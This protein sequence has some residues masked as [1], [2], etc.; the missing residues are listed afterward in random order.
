MALN[1]SYE[2]P[3]DDEFLWQEYCAI[4][5]N[6][7]NWTIWDKLNRIVEIDQIDGEVVKWYNVNTWSYTTVNPVIWTDVDV[8]PAPASTQ[9]EVMVDLLP[10][11]EQNKFIRRFVI[12]EDGS[13]Q[14]T[15]DL[16]LDW[17]TAYT[18][19]WTVL[20]QFQRKNAWFQTIS[21]TDG[22]VINLTVP[23]G[24]NFAELIFKSSWSGASDANS[25]ISYTEEAGSPNPTNTGST[26]YIVRKEQQFTLQWDDELNNFK[27]IALT[28]YAWNLE[29]RYKF[30]YNTRD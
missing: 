28:G 7:G 23:T 1:P 27:A 14:S 26:G 19:A 20:H 29:V 8:C 18:V 12:A 3:T 6:A 30:D 4:T 13:T 17:V 21:I 22:S 10:T 25:A 9:E 5:T 2:I 15:I 11:W 16:Q 24:A